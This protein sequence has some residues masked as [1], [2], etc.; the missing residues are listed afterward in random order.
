MTFRPVLLALWLL[1][2]PLSLGAQE[3]PVRS[4]VRAATAA[5]EGDSVARVARR[6][7]AR[8]PSDS[9]ARLGL[10]TM[11][12]LTYQWKDAEREYQAL[13][14]S[15]RPPASPVEQQAALGYAAAMSSRL[16]D[17][18][19]ESLL[20][21]VLD[22]PSASPATR[23]EA[24]LLMARAA[25]RTAGV[26]SVARL[27]ERAGA[28]IPESNLSLRANYLCAYGGLLRLRSA[29]RADTLIQEGIAKAVAARDRRAEGR[30]RTAQG[31]LRISEGRVAEAHQS[32][33]AANNLLIRSRDQEGYAT[34]AQW[35]AYLAANTFSAFDD[36]TL[37]AGMAIKHGRISGNVSAVAYAQLNLGQVGLR[38]GDVV[39]ARRAAIQ[40][41]STFAAMADRQGVANSRMVAADAA[42]LAN[43]P[44]LAGILYNSADSIFRQIGVPAR[45]G[46]ALRLSAIALE[47]RDSAAASRLLEEAVRLASERGIQ[48]IMNTDRHYFAGLI[49]LRGGRYREAQEALAAFRR[50]AGPT[51]FH[52][53]LDA[54][55]RT[56]EA[57][58]LAGEL[59][60]ALAMFNS[61][62]LS[63]E[64]MRALL[65]RSSGGE[66]SRGSLVSLLQGRRFDFDTDLGIAT[67]VNAFVRAGRVG[68]AFGISAQ[69][70]SRYLLTAL[71]R[72]Q[73]V[74]GDSSAV[75][76]GRMARLASRTIGLDSV[77]AALP[78]ATALLHYT[79][80]RGGEPTTLIA[81]WRQGM[82][83]FTLPPADSLLDRLDRFGQAL[84]SGAPVPAL[85]A[86]LA[87]LLV[88]SAVSALP[89]GIDR[90]FIVPDGPLHRV[91]FDALM[92]SDGRALVERF[93]VS[94]APSPRIAVEPTIPARPASTLALG[95][96]LFDSEAGLAPLPSSAAEARAAAATWT[97]GRAF[98]GGKASEAT[99]KREGR[100][101]SIIHLAT[102]AGVQDWGVMTSALYLSPGTGEDGMVTVSEIAALPLERVSLVVLSGCRTLGGP[103]VTGEGVQGLTAP[104]LEAG[105]RAVV[106]TWWKVGD[107]AA[108]GF[109]NRFY[110][111]LRKGVTVADALRSAKL[112]SIKDGVSAS[113]WAAFAVTGDGQAR[114]IAP[115]R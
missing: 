13:M 103:I 65:S 43:E 108:T 105:A 106:A 35:I 96:A 100:S 79:T 63:L 107:R 68:D 86:E 55:L 32:L 4:V 66:N 21:Q 33:V 3:A 72:R 7:T 90:L 88:D 62:S 101:A 10:A 8:L 56:G 110:R 92:L 1:P 41:E 70:R 5:V 12:R 82:R 51:A 36:A 91:P 60:S 69:E 78:S 27:L 64:L 42:Y 26:D 85:S 74:I 25:S 75:A 67:T 39:V 18:E 111:E 28:L 6:W 22:A 19:V 34:A 76:P 38:V 20:R 40:A 52:Y 47:L 80:G 77:R 109:V 54:D 87:R 49:A 58:A 61:G 29:P 113:V 53:H 48:G 102:H 59:D 93:T 97:G 9:N 94:L 73:A 44:R 81:A 84:E 45:P 83:A 14:P 15:T 71:A 2:S 57:L 95:G 17:L 99:L 46:I 30:C 104:F 37:M 16:R 112:S 50:G 31:Q 24:L 114:F 11:A 98:V 115:R 89:A 23:A